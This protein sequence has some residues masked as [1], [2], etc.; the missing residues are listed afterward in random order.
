VDGALGPRRLS[1]QVLDL[2]DLAGAIYRVESQIPPRRTNPV[3]EWRITA[4]VRVPA[5]WQ[6]KGGPLLASALAFLNRADWIF[7]F[8][9]RVGGPLPQTDVETRRV[10]QI[11]LFSGGMDSACGAGSRSGDKREVQLVSFSTANQLL[12]LQRKLAAELG[13]LAPTQWRLVGQRGK[14]GMNLVRGLMFLSLGAAVA[15]SFGAREILQ[16]E[17]GLLA[18]ATPPSGN[19]ISTRHAHPEL[20]R[21]LEQ[22]FAIVFRERIQVIN[23]FSALTKR[24]TAQRL[25]AVLGAES[26]ETILR[27]TQT[28]WYLW[29][30]HVAGEPKRP[31]VPC[32]VCAPCIVRRTARPREAAKDVWPGWRG[33]AYDLCLPRVQR[34]ARLGLTF[35]AYLELIDIGTT[36]ADD[37]DLIDQLAPEARALVGGPAGPGE[38]ETAGLIRR[39]AREFCETFAIA[40]RSGTGEPG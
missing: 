11:I 27:Q 28:C 8:V 19:F 34:H 20:H 2:L 21:R 26:A 25:A 5:F 23:P 1:P 39:F 9:P 3:R 38:A 6:Q 30:A 16:Y 14:E 35:R 37:R 40:L 12:S 22:L 29:Q 33:Y 32:G 31:G 13:Y 4:P 7:T 24:E 10:R 18:S 17:N 36:A 15:Y